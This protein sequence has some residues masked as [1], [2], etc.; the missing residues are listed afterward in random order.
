INLT[1][2]ACNAGKGENPIAQQ[3]SNATDMTVT[4]YSNYVLF[5]QAAQ[6]S[7]GVGAFI[8]GNLLV[9]LPLSMVYDTGENTKF[10]EKSFT[11]NL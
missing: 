11:P 3:I 7:D 9:H 4:A 6:L 8:L 2:I 1:L 10:G 5:N